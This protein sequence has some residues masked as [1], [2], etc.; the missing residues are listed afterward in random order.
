[1]AKPRKKSGTTTKPHPAQELRHPAPDLASAALAALGLLITAYL[2]YV[3]MADAA[4]VLCSAGSSCDLIQKSH[5]SR[6]FGVPIAMWG[7]ATYA[8]ILAAALLPAT[9]MRRWRRLWTLSLLGVA[10]SLY[11]TIVGIVALEAICL[12]CLASLATL[13]ALL[14]VAS[15]RRPAG[16]PGMPWLNWSLR[17]AALLVCVI[18]VMQLYYSGLFSPRPEPRLQALAQH[19]AD[20]DA[21]FYGAFWCP[22]CREQKALFGGAADALPYVECSPSGRGGPFTMACLTAGVTNF[23]TWNIRGRSYEGV[24]QPEEL[25][26]RSGFDWKGY[27]DA[28]A[29]P[30][31]GK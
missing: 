22:S 17:H 7:F 6:L 24:L 30:A 12:W 11:L 3:A 8:L 2:S 5:W 28:R 10:I 26:A 18:G 23:P 25:A 27:S 15:L 29:A 4:P 16:A 9:R 31:G 14:A 19:L 20:T 21:R 13:L 1:M